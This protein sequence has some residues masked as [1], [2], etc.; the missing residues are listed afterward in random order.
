ME[1]NMAKAPRF[2]Q[3][4]VKSAGIAW[5][6][7]LTAALAFASAPPLSVPLVPQSPGGDAADCS[8]WSVLEG[9]MIALDGEDDC[10]MPMGAGGFGTCAD[11]FEGNPWPHA[12]PR[13]PLIACARPFAVAEID[14]LRAQTSVRQ[15][16]TMHSTFY[17]CDCDGVTP[18]IAHVAKRSSVIFSRLAT[19]NQARRF[20]VSTGCTVRL[21]SKLD[22]TRSCSTPS[23]AGV[24]GEAMWFLTLPISNPEA[25]AELLRNGSRRETATGIGFCTGQTAVGGGFEIGVDGVGASWNYE[26]GGTVATAEQV[27]S[28]FFS[29]NFCIASD[30]ARYGLEFTARGSVTASSWLEG[31]KESSMLTEV[32][33]RPI[34]IDFQ[35]L[36]G[37]TETGCMACVGDSV[38]SPHPEQV[39]GEAE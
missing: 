7:G 11:G 13:P 26:V 33:L 29:T 24:N 21:K 6:A 30:A 25:E 8:G 14:T 18:E 38:A 37:Q 3:V 35:S 17:Q 4:S 15:A 36:P 20:T 32:D 1:Q 5:V 10:P 16:K 39:G 31:G 22:I 23:C 19:S 27:T 28:A 2:T 9:R 34:K 12:Y